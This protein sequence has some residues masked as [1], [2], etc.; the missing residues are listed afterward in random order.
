MTFEFKHPKKYK[1]KKEYIVTHPGLTSLKKN[2]V[3]SEEQ[4]KKAK[5][6]FS[7]E[8]NYQTFEYKLYA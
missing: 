3:I 5:T 1:I 4:L 7:W 6:D 8:K 2:Q